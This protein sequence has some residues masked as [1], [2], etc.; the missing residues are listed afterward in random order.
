MMMKCEII[1][2]KVCAYSSKYVFRENEQHLLLP[3]CVVCSSAAYNTLVSTS[4]RK[5]MEDRG[6]RK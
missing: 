1:I 6:E 3:V 4:I 2:G 5:T